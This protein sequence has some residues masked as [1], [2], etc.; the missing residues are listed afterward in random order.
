[1]FDKMLIFRDF[2]NLIK[3]EPGNY[4]RCDLKLK[5]EGSHPRRKTPNKFWN[6]S[7]W[8][9]IRMVSFFPMLLC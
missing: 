9:E 6:V 3:K 5:V 2:I 4:M 1:M 7:T 8:M